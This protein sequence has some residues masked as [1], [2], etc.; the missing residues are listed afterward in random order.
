MV[1]GTSMR[2]WEHPDG[3]RGQFQRQLK[4]Y[5]LAGKVCGRCKKE[6]ISRILV[7]G[8][9]TWICSNCQK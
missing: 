4:V 6:R 8:R 2:D 7:G 5:G 1:R 3:S 9:G